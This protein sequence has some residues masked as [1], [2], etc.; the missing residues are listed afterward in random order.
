VGDEH[1]G[2]IAVPKRTAI[3]ELVRRASLHL[4][5]IDPSAQYNTVLY[6]VR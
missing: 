4:D 1:Y 3:G 6:L 2:I 5:T